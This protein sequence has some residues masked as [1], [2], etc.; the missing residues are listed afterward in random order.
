M[1]I[2]LHKQVLRKL[3]DNR[4]RGALGGLGGGQLAGA[5]LGGSTATQVGSSANVGAILPLIVGMLEKKA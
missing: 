4:G 1:S 3:A 5:A 2:W